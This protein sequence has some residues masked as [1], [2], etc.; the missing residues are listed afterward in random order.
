MKRNDLEESERKMKNAME[1]RRKV[2]KIKSQKGM[3][4]EYV[5]G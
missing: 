1:W 3:T 5:S 4:E 2:K